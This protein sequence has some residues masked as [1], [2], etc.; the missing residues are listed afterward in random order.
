MATKGAAN[1]NVKQ[2]K[3][4]ITLEESCMLRTLH[5]INKIKISTII[6]NKKTF[7]GFAKF[8]PA[9]I[10]RHAKKPLDGSKMLDRRHNNPG[11]PKLCSMYDKRMIKR[12]IAVLRAQHGTFSSTTL[13]SE[14]GIGHV[15]NATFRR[16]LQKL[17]YGYRRTRKKGMLT[18]K[19]YRK[20]LKFA[21]KVK[22]VFK[23][24]DRES[25]ILWTRGISMYVDGVGF[26]Y[27][28]NPYLHA[29]TPQAREWRLANEG[30]THTGKG[31]KEG[32]VQERFLVGIA[33]LG[34]PEQ[35]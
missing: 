18:Q 35:S 29:K 31:K 21:R 3:P 4:K 10:Y 7:P 30:L 9:T 16:E 17:G 25:H 6:Q 12:Q 5:Q 23:Q 22:R 19:D 28:I 1:K 24:H 20:R 26:E 15:S 32:A 34:V 11:R 8:S 13:Q 27:K 14:T 33:G 2:R